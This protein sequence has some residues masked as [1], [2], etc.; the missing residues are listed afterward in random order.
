MHQKSC[1]WLTVK[2][3]CFVLFAASILMPNS[4]TPQEVPSNMQILGEITA[5]ADG[6]PV[7]NGALV[8]VINESTLQTVGQGTILDDNGNYFIDMSQNSDFNGTRLTLHIQL[9]NSV[10][11]LLDGS[12]PIS[13]QYT[14]SFPFPT[15]LILN[16][17]VGEFISSLGGGTGA[18]S[19]GGGS[20]VREGEII[21]DNF[22]VNDDGVFNQADI[23]LIKESIT[24]SNPNPRAD[25]NSDGVINTRDAITAIR[26]WTSVRRRGSRAV[27]VE[28]TTVSDDDVNTSGDGSDTDGG[29]TQ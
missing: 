11:Q 1:S 16:G 23:D 24:S 2:N 14:G 18:V 27:T 19:G 17:T 4:A 13:F 21:N 25:V 22:D 29:S 12:S 26:F 10:F 3:A 9:D 6:P 15:R 28:R 7:T 8:L 20:S 5:G